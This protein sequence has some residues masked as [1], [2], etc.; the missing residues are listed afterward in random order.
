MTV[1]LIRH[2]LTAFFMQ[3]TVQLRREKTFDPP[4]VLAHKLSQHRQRGVTFA[5]GKRK[6]SVKGGVPV[7]DH[8]S[9]PFVIQT[10]RRRQKHGFPGLRQR[11][12]KQSI[13]EATPLF[14]KAC[15]NQ[16]AVLL[17]VGQVDA[18]PLEDGLRQ[19]LHHLLRIGG[20]RNLL[21]AQAHAGD[22]CQI[23]LQA[24][25][26]IGRH[27]V[28]A[29]VFPHQLEQWAERVIQRPLR[30]GY[31]LVDDR[32]VFPAHQVFGRFN[33]A[34][35]QPLPLLP[36]LPLPG[37]GIHQGNQRR[38]A[39]IAYQRELVGNI[40]DIGRRVESQTVEKIQPAASEIG[41]VA[42]GQT[43]FQRLRRQVCRHRFARIAQHPVDFLPARAGCLI[44]GLL[45]AA[46]PCLA[47]KH[48]RDHFIGGK[49]AARVGATGHV[50]Q[51]H[52][53]KITTHGFEHVLI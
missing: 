26:A 28:A 24:Q 16:A 21:Q 7:G 10:G 47:G 17:R 29:R 39:D 44:N 27:D 8:R 9:A 3:D 50:F 20:I 43:R 49:Q 34:V 42:S 46:F 12:H 45:N 5:G 51:R 31:R 2:P 36:R 33:K 25:G 13:T 53:G 14:A 6:A 23:G 19:G 30:A 32:L 22:T 15:R 4:A 41:E 38:L 18:F 35:R 40:G 52:I 37:K 1:D 48:P 11:L